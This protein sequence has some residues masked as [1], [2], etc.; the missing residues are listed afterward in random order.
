MPLPPA[1]WQDDL[2]LDSV[3]TTSL[4]NYMPTLQEQVLTNNFLYYWMWSRDR[5]RTEDGGE[6]IIVPLMYGLNETVRSY[7]DYETLDVSPQDGMTPA[8]YQWKQLAGSISISRKEE[9]ANSSK[10]RIISLLESKVEQ[11][12]YSWQEKLGSM[13]YLDGTG[14]AGK[15]ILGLDALV[16]T[17]TGGFGT[18]AGIDAVAGGGNEWWQPTVLDFDDTYTGTQFDQTTGMHEG[19][20]ITGQTAVRTLYRTCSVG[21][22][23]PDLGITHGTTYE[24]YEAA[25][26]TNQRHTDTVTA[27]HGFDNLKHRNAVVAWEDEYILADDNTTQGGIGRWYFLNS[28]FLKV[29]IDSATNFLQTPFVRPHNQDAR[30]SQTLLMMNL[31]ATNRKRQGVLFDFST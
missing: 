20:I 31:V 2:V 16:E 10:N 25:L 30:T 1:Q 13:A 15:D 4:M 19:D 3:L 5:I 24:Q 21:A 9:R 14:N 17:G 28:K 22:S 7:S 29:V 8:R 23:Q 6:S 18:L 26:T 11:L 27:K 12:E